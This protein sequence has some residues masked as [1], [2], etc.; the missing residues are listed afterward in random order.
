MF[1]KGTPYYLSASLIYDKV[2]S[3]N[4]GREEDA[5]RDTADP[6]SD[7][8]GT[9]RGILIDRMLFKIQRRPNRSGR[10]VCTVLC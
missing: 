3:R 4:L 6:D 7:H 10:W 1:R 2:E 5:S 8:D 9:K